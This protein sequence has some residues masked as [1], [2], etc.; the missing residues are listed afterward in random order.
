MMKCDGCG[1]ESERKDIFKSVRRSFR[2]SELILCPA[3]FEQKDKKINTIIIWTY[4]ILG[5]VSLPLLLFTNIRPI[6]FLLLN[7][8]FLQLS[9]LAFT[10]WHEI[11]HAVVGRIVGMRVFGI[12]IGKGRVVCEFRFCGMFWRFRTIP[13]G[14]VAYGA[15]Y[16]ARFFRIRKSLSVF[17]GPLANLIALCI[18]IQI[19]SLNRSPAPKLLDDFVPIEIFALSNFLMLVFSLW[20]YMVNSVAGRIPSDGLF[21]WKVWWF[22]DK[23]I[24]EN[25]AARYYLEAIEHQKQKDFVEAQKW[26]EDGLRRFPDNIRLK[27][28]AAGS[29]FRLKKYPE[30]LRAYALLIGRDKKNKNLD[31]LLLNDIAY[32]YLLIG[33]SELL[34]K[35]DTCSRI[36]FEK[37]PWIIYC[38]GTRGSVL[39]EYGKY[40]EGLKLLHE[41]MKKH[42]EKSGQALNACYIGIAEA[43]RGNANE[44]RN[45][46][47]IA[48]KLDPDC[49]LLERESTLREPSKLP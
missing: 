37:L 16:S 3:C 14:G 10:I 2:S 11:G 40:D 34:H 1:L 8:S 24:E 44:S 26:L 21:L 42:P 47:A 35:A 17:G 13:F 6:G 15:S 39:V 31:A 45:Y 33:K 23:Q 32:T 25:L 28:H 48:K 20:P 41:A 46:F 36:A 30:A 22:K 12:E 49:I 38:K 18:S 4:A 19:L 43:R 5:L 27:I 9:V 7:I 29:L